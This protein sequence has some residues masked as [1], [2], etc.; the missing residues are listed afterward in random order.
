MSNGIETNEPL[1]PQGI[2]GAI[3]WWDENVLVL[4][5]CKKQ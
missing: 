4:L 1:M 5:R 3:R 2:F